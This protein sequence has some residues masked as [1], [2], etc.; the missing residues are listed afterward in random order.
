MKYTELEKDLINALGG[1]LFAYALWDA[2]DEL[3]KNSGIDVDNLVDESLDDWSDEV[4]DVIER[5]EDE[6]EEAWD[7][8]HPAPPPTVCPT[9]RRR[10]AAS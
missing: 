4:Y 10:T 3:L 2:L 6:A 1:E 9:C 8:A 7:A 5:L